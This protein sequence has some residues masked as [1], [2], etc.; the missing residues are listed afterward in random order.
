[1]AGFARQAGGLSC[2]SCLVGGGSTSVYSQCWTG[3]TAFCWLQTLRGYISK[4]RQHPWLPRLADLLSAA[5][6][7]DDI[8]CW[9]SGFWRWWQKR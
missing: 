9:Q 1:M 8:I 6:A 4:Q 3:G 7:A 5:A 2:F